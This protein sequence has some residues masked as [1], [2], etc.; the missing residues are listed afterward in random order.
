MNTVVGS[1]KIFRS[2]SKMIP[3]YKSFI[4][5]RVRTPL[6]DLTARS[7][8][9]QTAHPIVPVIMYDRLVKCI[10]T[11]QCLVVDARSNEEFKEAG[12]IPTSINVPIKDIETTFSLPA[13]A[14]ENKFQIPKP[15]FTDLIVCY[16]Y[17]GKRSIKAC[18][19]L[20][21]MGYKN[22]MNYSAGWKNWKEN[23]KEV[24]KK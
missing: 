17:V 7:S 8:T 4:Q 24:E 3:K 5:H 1:F 23:T 19:M 18:N 11:K 14:F 10:Q 13:E 20:I 2:L 6:G 15:S 21:A 9:S 16:C 12:A 22:V